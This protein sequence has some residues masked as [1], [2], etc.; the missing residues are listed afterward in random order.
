MSEVKLKYKPKFTQSARIEK[1][2][3]RSR[4]LALAR[5]AIIKCYRR[6]KS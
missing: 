2:A 3:S 5:C 6:D 1:L 4:A